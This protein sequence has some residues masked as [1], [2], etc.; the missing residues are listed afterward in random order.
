MSEFKFS[1]PACGQDVLCDT[2]H[3]GTQIAC[4]T[5]NATIT[6][7]EKT[8]GTTDVSTPT[9]F[10]PALPGNVAT[11]GQQTSRLAIASLVCSLSSFITCIGWLPGIV[12]GHLAKSRIRRNPSL[13]GAGLATAGLVIGYLIFISEIGCTAI[14]VWRISNAVKQGFENA[15]QELATNPVIVMQPQSVPVSKENQQTGPVQ[16][17]AVVTN[18]QPIESIRPMTAAAAPQSEPGLSGWA[19]DIS[20]VSFPDRPVSG[21]LHGMDFAAKTASFRNGDLKLRAANGMVLDVYRLGTAIEGRS[22][23]IRSEDDDP[24]NPRVKMTWNEGEAV[25]TAT[26]NKGYGMKLRFGQVINRKVS[27]KLYLCFPDDAK[28]CVAG[29]FE[30]RLPQQP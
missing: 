21:K 1:C 30:V 20:N 19:S 17:K 5:C 24:A 7:P 2:T 27:G 3:V 23:E 22:Y 25:Q 6:V 28:S 29:T 14:Y 9:D 16:T 26:F 8:A 11:T 12:C 15:R 4:P 13:K 10:P 18:E